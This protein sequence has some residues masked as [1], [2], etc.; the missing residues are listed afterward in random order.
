M[1][2]ECLWCEAEVNI[3]QAYYDAKQQ[4]HFCCKDH[5]DQFLDSVEMEKE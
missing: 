1:N 5:R 4:E 3:N 2:V